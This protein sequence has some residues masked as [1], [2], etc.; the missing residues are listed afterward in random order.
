MG[1]VDV[2]RLIE[3]TGLRYVV[4]HPF[5]F[6]MCIQQFIARICQK[7]NLFTRKTEII[8]QIIEWEYS[9]TSAENIIAKCATNNA[10]NAFSSSTNRWHPLSDNGEN[11]NQTE[12]DNL[13]ETDN[14]FID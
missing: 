5:Y 3:Y 10:L 14:D 8:Q 4:D 13:Y 9:A 2:Y 6:W 12:L 1:Q 11:A 7:L